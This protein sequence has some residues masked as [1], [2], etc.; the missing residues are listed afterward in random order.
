VGEPLTFD[1]LRGATSREIAAAI[2]GDRRWDLLPVRS[3]AL[4]IVEADIREDVARPHET[5][6][7]NS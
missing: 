2:L 7:Q 6:L 1:L 5:T 3:G 4:R